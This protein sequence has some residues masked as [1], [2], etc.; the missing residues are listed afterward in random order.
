MVVE[1]KK[2]KGKLQKYLVITLLTLDSKNFIRV[3][4]LRHLND[5]KLN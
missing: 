5:K 2:D 4:Q 3:V 1:E